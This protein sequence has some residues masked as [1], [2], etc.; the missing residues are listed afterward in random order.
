MQV[1]IVVERLSPRLRHAIGVLTQLLSLGVFVLISWQ[2]ARY[3]AA[4]R[5]SGEVSMTLGLPFYPVVHGVAFSFAA[6]AFVLGVDLL[7][8][9]ARPP[10]ANEPR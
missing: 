3:A 5:E 8:S 6:A 7:G 4:L 10:A 2:S 9:A 1:G